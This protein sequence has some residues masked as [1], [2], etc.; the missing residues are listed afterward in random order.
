MRNIYARNLRKAILTWSFVSAVVLLLSFGLTISLVHIFAPRHSQVSVVST[1]SSPASKTDT[2]PTATYLPPL[3]LEIASLAVDALVVAVGLTPDDEMDIEEDIAKTAWY[4][5]GP[6]PGEKGSA[7]IAGHYGWKN[8]QESVFTHLH[9]LR[10]GDTVSVHDEKGVSLTFIVREIRKY[11]A[12]ADA[13]EVF[14]ST[15][16]KAH[17]NLITCDGSWNS[18]RQTYSDRL[19]VFTDLRS[20]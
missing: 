5:F 1:K 3:R 4:K 20:E 8:G 18:S 13:T 16:G 10:Q 11:D 9:S 7:V 15:D 17:L 2:T 12:D 19:V 6:K 14:R